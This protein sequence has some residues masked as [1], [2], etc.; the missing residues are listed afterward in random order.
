MC[1][2]IDAIIDAVMRPSSVTE[3]V[4]F[5]FVSNE[6]AEFRLVNDLSGTFPEWK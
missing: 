5:E 4:S 2:A 6:R 3:T 1:Y